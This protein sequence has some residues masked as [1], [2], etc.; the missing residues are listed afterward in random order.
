MSSKNCALLGGGGSDCLTDC[1][2][3]G[4]ARS[5]GCMLLAGRSGNVGVKS[6]DEAG[7]Y[8]PSELVLWAIRVGEG[9]TE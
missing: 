7:A 4:P 1:E 2:D 3:I 8:L 9:G 6:S 5:E